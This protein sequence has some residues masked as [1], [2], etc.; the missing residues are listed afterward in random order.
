MT[1]TELQTKRDEILKRVGVSRAQFGDKS[2][3]YGEAKAALEVID[4]EISK[5]NAPTSTAR[6]SY[7]S[8]SDD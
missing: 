8:F 6:V 5:L 2:V 4:A 3:Q 7:A 1:I